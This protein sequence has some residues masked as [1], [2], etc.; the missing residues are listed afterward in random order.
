MGISLAGMAG[1]LSCKG[2]VTGLLGRLKI[3]L[4]EERRLKDTQNLKCEDRRFQNRLVL[5][6]E[7]LAIKPT[8]PED[9][10]FASLTGKI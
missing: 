1:L 6:A 3:C 10:R 7:D 4:C 8:K 9:R 5:K 2:G